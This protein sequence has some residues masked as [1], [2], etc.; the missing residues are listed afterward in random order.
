MDIKIGNIWTAGAFLIALQIGAFTWKGKG[1]KGDRRK[2]SRRFLAQSIYTPIVRYIEMPER[3]QPFKVTLPLKLL[4]MISS[5]SDYKRLDV[6][7]EK[8]MLKEALG[9]LQKAGHLKI[10]WTEKASLLALHQYLRN[11]TYHVFH[12]I[13]HG[14]FDKDER[15]GVLVFEDKHGISYRAGPLRLS[16]L[17][18]DHPSL[19]LAVLNSC[20]GARN[21]RTDPFAGVATRLVLQ[22]IPAVIAMQ[23]EIT[24]NAAIAFASEFYTRLAAGNPVDSALSD[25][26][27]AIFVQPNDI[28]WGTPVLY[29]HSQNGVLFDLVED[30]TSKPETEPTETAPPQ[31]NPLYQTFLLQ[32]FS[33]NQREQSR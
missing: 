12:F 21:S 26:R 22:G 24:D 11:S 18:Q 33:I 7:R 6:E 5:P 31:P 23:F 28:E 20:E 8:D 16:A 10:K 13:G 32:S 29:M 25:A 2:S 17:L 15:E 9:P 19:R 14:G 4:V 1:R 27:K 30:K 3:L